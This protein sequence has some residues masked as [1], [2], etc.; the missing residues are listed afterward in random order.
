MFLR[1]VLVAAVSAATVLLSGGIAHA[2]HMMP[3]SPASQENAVREAKDYLSDQGFSR[4]G[5]IKQLEYDQFSEQDATSA[6]DSL[7]VDWNAEAVRAAKDYLRDQGFSH[8]GLV[9]QLEYDGFTSSQA[10]YGVTA[11]GV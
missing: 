10:E 2:D 4:Q 6:V 5:L 3:R 1:T 7:N 11:A 9:S 8:G